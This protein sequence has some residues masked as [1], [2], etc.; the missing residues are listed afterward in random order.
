MIFIVTDRLDPWLRYIFEQFARVNGLRSEYKFFL[1]SQL[2]ETFSQRSDSLILEYSPY[3]K[4]S[5]SFFVPRRNRFKTDDYT[6]IRNDLPVFSDTLG[7]NPNKFDIFFNAFVHLSRL[8][9]WLSEKK[10]KRIYSLASKHPRK[11][12]KIWKIPVVNHLFNLIED[13][14][15]RHNKMILF[16][17]KEI[18]FIEFSHDVD[19]LYKTIQFRIKQC[20]YSFLKSMKFL[21]HDRK[22]A[23]NSFKKGILSATGNANYRLFN[24]WSELEKILNIK[25]VKKEDRDQLLLQFQQFRM[26]C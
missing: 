20:C 10:G 15:K 14:I 6:W 11:D 16:K 5:K 8:E 2:P 25:S 7:E 24:R 26:L 19:Y 18:P 13:E 21:L 9:E 1:Y 22:K 3:K 17:K 4:L 23:L 12:H